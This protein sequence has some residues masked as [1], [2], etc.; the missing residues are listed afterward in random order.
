MTAPVARTEWAAQFPDGH[1]EAMYTGRNRRPYLQQWM[2]D[3]GV[4]L[5]RRDVELQ[6][7]PWT[8]AEQDVAD[9]DTRSET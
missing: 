1:H 3:A 6:F 7:G 2:R 8:R 9:G 5:V 4:V